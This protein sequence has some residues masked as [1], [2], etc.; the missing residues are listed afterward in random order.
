MEPHEALLFPVP[1]ILRESQERRPTQSSK[2]PNLHKRKGPDAGVQPVNLI[3]CGGL[4]PSELFS[5]TF[6]RAI[7][8]LCSLS[9]VFAISYGVYTTSD[10]RFCAKERHWDAPGYLLAFEA[11]LAYLEKTPAAEV[12]DGSTCTQGAI[13]GNRAGFSGHP[14]MA[15]RPSLERLRKFRRSTTFGCQQ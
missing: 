3:G 1:R 2:T 14:H 6:Q 12:S 15:K 7:D 9:L 8:T 13:P 5:H 10:E 4:Q 11:R